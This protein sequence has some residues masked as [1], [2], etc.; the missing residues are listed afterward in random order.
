MREQLYHLWN[1]Y[2]ILKFLKGDVW[3]T[4]REHEIC[5]CL[6]ERQRHLFIELQRFDWIIDHYV[7]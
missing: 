3:I 5:E 6:T 7:I 2:D 4:K 1:N